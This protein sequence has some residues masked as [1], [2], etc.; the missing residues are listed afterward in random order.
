MSSFRFFCV[1]VGVFTLI[2]PSTTYAASL[3]ARLKS[4][5]FT[6]PNQE[7]EAAIV[8][9]VTTHKILYEYNA[10]KPWTAASLTKLVGALTFID[11]Q[12]AWNAVVSIKEQDEVGGGRLRVEDGATMTI[13]DL[14]YASI[15]GSAN[16]AATAFARLSGLGLQGFVQAMNQKAKS[17]GCT[18]S[19]FTDPSGMDVGNTITARDLLKIAS[20]AFSNQ[21]I[22]RPASTAYY[23]FNI[24][25]T[26]EVKTIKSTDDL[27]L[28]PDNGLYV[29]G[30]K[31]GFLYESRN[32][33]VYKVRKNKDASDSELMIVVLGAYTRSD[34][35]SIAHKLADWSWDSYTWDS[36]IAASLPQT[37]NPTPIQPEPTETESTEFGNGTL[38]KTADSPS[39]WYI[40]NNKKYILLDGVFLDAYFPTS[41]ILTVKQSIADSL[42]DARPYT[43]DDGI[44]LKSKSNPTVYYMHNGYLRP[45]ISANAFETQGFDWDDIYTTSQFVLDN[46]KLG[47]LVTAESN[48]GTLLTAR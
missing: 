8:M 2:I 48:L 31:T 25:N 13:Q 12:P 40:Y 20:A 24:L 44:L 46:Y 15:T 11:R 22:Q 7:Y 29:T 37:T 1:L 21:Y 38:I 10:D 45:I 18:N 34:L 23:T 19:V 4:P 35:F 43:F 6:S 14:M 47:S 41:P 27:L 39:V 32:N 30:G 42:P 5:D 16:N 17:L 9:D 33:F 28:D 26:S 36:N 3:P